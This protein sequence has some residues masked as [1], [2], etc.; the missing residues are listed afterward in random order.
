[1]RLA[2]ACAARV[3]LEPVLAGVGQLVDADDRARDARSR[4]RSRRRRARSGRRGARSSARVPS[5]TRASSGRATIG[6]RTP[7]TSRKMAARSGSEASSVECVH[8]RRVGGMA[9]AKL[10][11]IGLVAGAFGAL[12]GVGGGIVIVP[13]LVCVLRLRPAPRLRDVARGDPDH[14]RR[15]RCDLCVPRRGEAGR[16][17][18][19]RPAR[20]SSACWRARRSSSAC[21]CARSPTASR[22]LLAIVGVRLHRLTIALVALSGSLGGVLA[23]LFGVGGGIVFVPALVFGLG[24]SQLHAEATSLLAILPTAAGR[25]VAAAPLRQHR[26]AGGADRRPRVDRRR[27]GAASPRPS[28]CPNRSCARLFGALLLITSVQI[29]WRARRGS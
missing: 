24:L 3:E 17:G 11:G 29:A 28:R 1:M 5:G 2:H 26:P 13:L 12:F 14:G 25:L 15:R 23:G 7:S 21:R 18:D 19:R 20:P 9:T 4:G 22:S 27:P 8:A 10:V 16:G 6:A